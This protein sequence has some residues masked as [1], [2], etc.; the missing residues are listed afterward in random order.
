MQPLRRSDC[1]GCIATWDAILVLSA[2]DSRGKIRLC[3]SAKA[4]DFGDKKV[5]SS[6]D[7]HSHL[8][9]GNSNEAIK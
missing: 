7:L 1:A 9:Y 8:F 4:A 2:C 5:L 3:G 6:Y